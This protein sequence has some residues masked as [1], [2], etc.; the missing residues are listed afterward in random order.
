M[1][2]KS[3]L[4]CLMISTGAITLIQDDQI[5]NGIPARG[6]GDQFIPEDLELAVITNE[7]LAPSFEPF[8]LWKS[9][10]GIKTGIFLLD[11]EDGILQGDGM[12]DAARLFRFIEDIYDIT[13]GNLTYVLLGGDSEIVP[14]REMY[15]GASEFGL[16]DYYVSDLYYSS[17][18][19]QWDA[20]G[21]GKYG[22]PDD[23]EILGKSNITFPVNVGRVPVNTPE[24][25]SRYLERVISYE[26]DPP[27]GDWTDRFILSSSI[28]ERPN[29]LNDPATPIDEGFD[30]G[31]DNGYT[32]MERL[33]SHIPSSLDAVELHDY[34]RY[35]G[36]NYSGEN[37]TFR[38]NSLP[39][40]I[41][42][43]ASMVT[44]AG[45]SFYDIDQGI[46]PGI[47]YSLAQWYDPSGIANGSEGF[48]LALNYQDT[49]NL[50]NGMKL[51]MMYISSCDSFNFTD[52]EDRDLEN[53]LYAPEGG[54]ISVV[55]STGVSWR[56]EISNY[57]TGFGN[58]YLLPRYWDLTLDTHLPGVSL[59]R[60][61]GSYLS[62]MYGTLG[63]TKKVLADLYTYNFLGDPSLRGWVGKPDEMAVHGPPEEISSGYDELEL[64]VLDNTGAPIYDA[65][66]S[67]YSNSSDQLFTSRTG[68]DGTASV[69]CRFDGPGKAW[70]TVTRKGRVPVTRNLT[71]L[72]KAPDVA[73]VPGSLKIEGLPLT[74]GRNATL[75]FEVENQGV[76]ILE[77]VEVGFYNENPGFSSGN[78]PDPNK[79][80]FMTI[81]PGER[82]EVNFSFEPHRSWELLFATCVPVT[83]EKDTSDNSISM[84][85]DVNARPTFIESPRVEMVEDNTTL[86]Y[87]DLSGY[88]FDDNESGDLRFW[89]NPLAPGWISIY[90]DGM[91]EIRPPENW[92]GLVRVE[93]FVSDGLVSDKDHLEIYSEPVNDPPVIL[94]LEKVLT[95]YVDRPFSKKLDIFDAEGDYVSVQLESEM[96]NLTL[97]GDTLRMIPYS[98]DQGMYDITIHLDDGRGGTSTHN[99]TIEI[100]FPEDSLFFKESSVY[101]P[102]ATVGEKYDY[103]IDIGGALASTALFSDNTSLFEIDPA[104]GEIS[105][106]PKDGDVGEHW[107]KITL[108]SGNTTV[109]RSF[110]L[111][112]GEKKEVD[113]YFFVI[114]GA[115]L[116]ILIILAIAAYMWKG[117]EVD[118]YGLEE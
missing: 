109:S 58:W 4:I 70:I 50:T 59:Y 97:V 27:S 33:Y 34:T 64:T 99:T 45:Q 100:T 38:Y 23:I 74:E 80:G 72:K 17:P 30:P 1:R 93:I 14:F 92:S 103:Q 87:L 112:V 61:K 24:E 46:S 44:F 3:L 71:L 79:Y 6:P 69:I 104:T 94:G 19:T 73:V 85:I 47:A 57:T 5:A 51:P 76:K 89:Y 9:R 60:L 41:S 67:V 18:G 111:E 2:V 52:E 37:D 53:I 12:D 16:D 13:G 66:V 8:R 83:G 20:N 113:L 62:G 40:N 102:R 54:A 55:G 78:W 68:P 77:D 11:G 96:E 32:A 29:I 36:M 31:E 117:T 7:V 56:G 82:V 110:V 88:V 101:L 39:E 95:A 26:K 105:F 35:W 81:G 91:A 48:A 115:I 114:G 49:Y 65:L 98:G 63:F 107:I 116:L 10:S 21:D 118:Q 75:L 106:T 15:A 28:M 42:G 43:G 25:A 22:G 108:E 86:E 90:E 84:E